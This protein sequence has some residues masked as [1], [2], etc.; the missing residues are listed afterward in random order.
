M[1]P[2]TAYGVA[3]LRA[4]R[5]SCCSGLHRARVQLLCCAADAG[6]ADSSQRRG[7]QG[8]AAGGRARSGRAAAGRAAARMRCGAPPCGTVLA[9]RQGLQ[10]TVIPA[11]ACAAPGLV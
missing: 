8:S 10:A 6:A 3:R 2:G 9:G 7:T 4:A 1:M 5:S 11:D